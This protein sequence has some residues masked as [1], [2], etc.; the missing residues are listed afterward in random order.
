VDDSIARHRFS[1]EL[2]Y[3]DAHHPHQTA[4]TPPYVL[5]PVRDDLGGLIGLDPCT[6]EHNPTGAARF[7]FPPKHDGLSLP[8]DA[9]TIF[10]N[11][12]YGKAKEAW[13]KRC[14]AAGAQGRRVILLMPARTEIRTSHA[15]GGDGYRDRASPRQ[16]EVRCVRRDPGQRPSDGGVAWVRAVRLER[17]A[18]GVIGT[19]N[20]GPSCYRRKR[21]IG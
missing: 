9:D 16:G 18:E 21:N 14:V 10:V 5:D 6:T 20:A 8:W 12:P 1:N 11:P 2:R 7:Y 3:R 17:G 13:V 15:A 4:L 19:G